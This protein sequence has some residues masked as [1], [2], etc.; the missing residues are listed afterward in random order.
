MYD[1][2]AGR[3][4]SGRHKTT[5]SRHC[6]RDRKRGDEF[7]PHVAVEW[8][9]DH[10]FLVFLHP[11]LPPPPGMEGAASPGL[12]HTLLVLLWMKSSRAE[13]TLHFYPQYSNTGGLHC[14]LRRAGTSLLF[15]LRHLDGGI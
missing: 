3:Y 9:K 5:S 11:H 10:P 14:H 2:A 1:S 12:L 4:E 13:A 8:V 15:R 6:E 7:Q